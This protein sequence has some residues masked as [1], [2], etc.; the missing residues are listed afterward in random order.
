[1]KILLLD[2]ETSPLVV[3]TWGLFDKTVIDYRNIVEEWTF[4]SGAWKWFGEKT[5]HAIAVDPRIPKDDKAVVEALVEVISSA[6]VVVAHYGD[7]FDLPKIKARAI[8]HGLPP[9]PPR[10]TV[11]TKKVAAKIF[12]FTAN[13]LDYLGGF[14][15]VGR[16]MST[17]PGLW[18]K[19]LEGD[20][21][22][23]ATMVKYN[24]QDVVLLE[25]VYKKLR[26]YMTT[27]PNAGIYEA[28]D[29]CPVCGS[30]VFKKQGFKYNRTTKRQ[31]YQCQK[32]GCRAWFTGEVVKTGV[33][34][35]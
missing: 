12:G 20:E 14:L 5:V 30:K 27:H 22:A 1:M 6:D 33:K 4:I 11:D 29:S 32:E 23:L 17:P 18:T 10:P 28:V 19:V 26:P 25:E 3:T 24:K 13:R 16:K 21:D 2:T 9:I 15:G 31:Q 7:A 35:R 34:T 8:Y